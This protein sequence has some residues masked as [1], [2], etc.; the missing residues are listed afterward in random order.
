MRFCRILLAVVATLSLAAI[1]NAQTPAADPAVLNREAQRI[2]V[3]T[4]LDRTRP[5][6][7][8]L[9][10]VPKIGFP[11]A[12]TAASLLAVAAD[13]TES[14][15]IRLEALKKH[16][17][18]DKWL[19][20]VLKILDDPNDGGELLDS[21][22]TEH[23]NRRATF[24]LPA[25]VRQ[26]I[27]TTWRKLLDDPRDRVRLSAYRV[28]VANHD[29]VAVNRLSESL[30]RQSGIPIPLDEAIELLDLNGPINHLNVLRPY[31]IHGDPKVRAR[32]ARALAA[33]AQSRGSIVQMANDP[34]LA[35]EVRLYALRGLA[36]EDERFGSYA[37]ALVENTREDGDVRFAAMH[38]Y[39]GRLNYNRSSAE[40]QIRFALAVERIAADQEIR[41]ESANRLRNEARKLL[42]HLK[43]A[44]PSVKQFYDAR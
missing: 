14:D 2:A 3:Q 38:G 24:K 8:R 25:D 11:D 21:G 5:E 43:V 9:A 44:F 27:Q 35:A 10:A 42:E 20:L 41:S 28:L 16:R 26:R 18:D 15:A 17:F 40:E 32:A 33:D 39:A 6:K 13:R 36:R 30:R 22:L 1:V 23:L 12:T 7:E 29:P 37:I 31:L 4:F 34:Q 19:D